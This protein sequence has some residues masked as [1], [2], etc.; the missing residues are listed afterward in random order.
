M[1][2]FEST[3]WINVRM[4]ERLV[5][6]GTHEDKKSCLGENVLTLQTYTTWQS[7]PWLLLG[8]KWDVTKMQVTFLEESRGQVFTVKKLH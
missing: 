4:H 5:G 1:C 8:P 2:N 7:G 6:S 3:E